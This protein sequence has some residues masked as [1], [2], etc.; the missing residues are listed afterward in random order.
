MAFH[1]GAQFVARQR[2]IFEQ[3][4][5]NGF[6]LVVM[7]GQDLLGGGLAILDQLAHFLVDDARGI[8]AHQLALRHRMAQEHFLII[9]L[10]AHAAELFAHA[11]FHHHRTGQAGG[12]LDIARR[13]A[14]DLFRAE[15]DDLG[16]AAAEQ[17]GQ[18][19]QGLFA[20]ERIAVAF[21]QGHHHAQGA[22][23]RNDRRLVDRVD[24]GHLE[25]DDGVAGLVIGGQ[26]L[27]ILGHGHSA[28][29]GAHH[30]LVLRVFE[31]GMGDK[32]LVAPRRHQGR[33]VDQVHQ[34]GAR[35][36]GRAAGQHLEIDIRR[37]RH[38]AD[39][40][41]EHL[42]AA[43]DVRIGHHDLAVE[44][45][46]AQQRRIE[47]V[48]TVGG[49]DQDNAFIGLKAV[50]LD[51]QLVERLLA[52]VI[53]AT[54]PGA[55]LATDSIDFV[56]ED[57]AGR[58]LLGLLEHV[59]DAA[60]ADADEHFD[61]VG[62]G[63]GEEG[64]IGF[65]GNRAGQQRLAGTG[66]THQQHAARNTA[67]QALELARIA[68]EFHDLLEILLGFVDTGHVLERHLAARFREQFGAR[69][70][71]A[72]RTALAATLHLPDEEEP[73]ADNDD[74][75]Q[76][77]AEQHRPERAGLGRP[78]R[79]RHIAGFKARNDVGAIGQHGFKARTVGK[80]T[81][82]DI[83]G[84]GDT[85]DAAGLNVADKLAIALVGNGNRAGR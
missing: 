12:H 11:P 79:D 42:F 73:D 20:A 63:N 52:F 72:H 13:A 33:L 31:F 51:Q 70:A 40:D 17:H 71:K 66:R 19:G 56:D 27:F 55:T 80:H 81:G 1:Q 82:H 75:G 60:G 78:R 15:L 41:L 74:E 4:L 46:R 49:G 14:R 2:L 28:A 37:Q 8:V 64:H 83:V 77:G 54:Q 29:L 35:K 69:L 18:P 21:G 58:V 16:L 7:G 85:I 68:Q 84:N 24:P 76:P 32:A 26:L 62:T 67:T 30:D 47:H 57:D 43:G 39:M 9:G 50:H 10:V 3:R 25:R 38:L 45:A 6:P 53:A 36:A 61:K 48:G 5:G 59:A 65:A 44:A 34:I 22:A 23:A